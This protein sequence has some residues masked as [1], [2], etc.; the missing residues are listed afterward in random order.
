MYPGSQTLWEIISFIIG[1]PGPQLAICASLFAAM[2][3]LTWSGKRL[4]KMRREAI[5]IEKRCEAGG[6]SGVADHEMYSPFTDP[7]RIPQSGSY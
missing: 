6:V 5:D 3:F 1:I 2:I 7:D 4:I